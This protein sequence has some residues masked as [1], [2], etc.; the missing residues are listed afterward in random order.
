M[1]NPSLSRDLKLRRY[2]AN[3]EIWTINFLNQIEK[4]K[5]ELRDTGHIKFMTEEDLAALTITS[6]YMDRCSHDLF[7]LLLEDENLPNFKSEAAELIQKFNDSMHKVQSYIPHLHP[8]HMHLDQCFATAATIRSFIL[9][10][11]DNDE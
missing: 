3:L 1:K 11:T 10:N 6:E 2:A 9:L 5:Y 7:R 8:L 4:V